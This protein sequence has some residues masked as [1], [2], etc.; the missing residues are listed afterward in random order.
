MCPKFV[1][2]KHLITLYEFETEQN[3][4]GANIEKNFEA[5]ENT[6]NSKKKKKIEE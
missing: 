1:R 3:A 2:R 4:L 5:F 6:F